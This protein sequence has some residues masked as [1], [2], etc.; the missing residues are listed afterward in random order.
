[1]NAPRIRNRLLCRSQWLTR[2]CFVLVSGLLAS[3]GRAADHGLTYERDI[4]PIM[5]AHCFDCHGATQ[6][7]EGSLDLRQVRLMLTGGDSGSAIVPGRADESLLLQRIRSGEMPP[8]ETKV[9]EQELATLTEWIAT[10]AKT[11]RPEPENIPPGLGITPEE[12][13]FWSFQPIDRPESPAVRDDVRSRV[14]TQIDAFLLAEMPE[15]LTF[16]DDAD[17][18][19]LILRAYFD[20][21]GL[22]P[23]V[24]EIRRWQDEPSGDW[25][26]QMVESLLQSKHYGER[27]ARHWLDVAGYADS[28]GFTVNDPE[29]PWAW[30]YRDYVIRSFNDDKPFDRFITEQLAGD[31]LAS[32]ASG[33][34][35]DEQIELLTATGYLRMAAD[36]TGSGENN[37]TARNQVIGDTLKIVSTS[38]LGLSVG[39]AQCHDHRYDPIPQSDYYA[40]RAVFA[41]ALDWQ[42]WKVPSQRMI[43]LY[44]EAERKQAAEI[45]AEAAKIGEER[46]T[47][48]AEYM[49][50]ALEQ[51]LQKYAEPLR[52]S[53]KT[54]Y[55]TPADKR[56]PEQT[57]LLD[58]NPSVKIT[59]GVLY[60]YLPKAAEDLKTYDARMAEVRAKKPPEEFLA[61]LTEPAG[62]LPET[63][64]F[65]R[66]D[67]QQPTD[68]VPPA[69]LTVACAEDAREEFPVNDESLPTS[70]RRL[71]F[72][73]WLTSPDNPLVARVIVNRIW[74]HHFGSG[75]VPTPA[76]FGRLGT[77]PTHPELLDWLADE[78]M[79][80]GWSVK[81]LHRV[82]LA[83]TAWRQSSRKTA[84]HTSLDPDNRF[85]SRQSIVRL[86]AELVRDRMLNASGRLSEQMFGRPAPVREDDA[87]QVV[88]D[89]NETRRSLYI[90]VRRTQP[91][92]MLQAFDAPVME[93]NCEVRPVST[94]ATQSLMLMNSTSVLNH[95]AKLAERSR[96]EATPISDEQLATLP[97]VPTADPGQWR[98]GFGAFD[99]TARQTASFTP[100]PHF[101]GSQW[102]GGSALPDPELGWVLLNAGGGH[103]DQPGRAVIR[104]WVAPAPGT[105]T[106]SGSLQ[107]GS[108]NGDGVRGR[109]VR[110]AAQPGDGLLGEW[111]CFNTKV[112]TAVSTATVDAGDTIDFITDCLTGH[113]SDSFQWPVTIAFTATNGA[114]QTFESAAG[115]RGP[116]ET[117][118]SLAGQAVRAWQLAWCR[119]PEPH[120]LAAAIEFLAE[121]LQYIRTGEVA[122]PEGVTDMQQALT[123][124]CQVLMT[125][126]EFLYVK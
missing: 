27:W 125:S 12:R 55:E 106:I 110:S 67:F 44:T 47:K 65:H 59:P 72:A 42:D 76:D 62:H 45:E 97:E 25:Y 33:D 11:A 103:P 85:Y 64:L 69:A 16:A 109:V 96:N 111:P 63:H 39:C 23:A 5:R 22:P 107:H 79:Q 114:T 8:G 73:K 10:G 60:Q 74:L 53:L 124:L 32:P 4:R 17:R 61:V 105:L 116:A 66:G 31:E 40:M 104:R 13:A 41:P 7:T 90:K 24:D 95:A 119:D 51:E 120:E 58:Q 78:F 88:I 14:R 115:F 48:Q 28:D 26:S 77:E 56:T 121:Q 83:S 101:T 102:Q 37:P 82:I 86:D 70:G 43:S 68:I 52:T 54:A 57:T 81:H 80:H 9:S 108:P 84:M 112:D 123:N 46:A 1:M 100:L 29:R 2:C 92:A 21:T 71:A 117:A 36:G 35:T 30:K 94:V 98:F 50:Q 15:G 91:V 93:V 3:H 18:H 122:L 20:L 126:N 87:G 89:E 34:L 6:E 49:A 99:E 113:T 38:L 19:T 118:S 75:I